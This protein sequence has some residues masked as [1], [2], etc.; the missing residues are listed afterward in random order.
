MLVWS[1]AVSP[2]SPR[3]S[4]RIVVQDQPVVASS[5]LNAQDPPPANPV[6]PVPAVPR[7]K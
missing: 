1:D 5:V 7:V 3:E 4:P 6:Y 2:D